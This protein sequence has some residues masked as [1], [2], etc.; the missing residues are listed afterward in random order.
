LVS[1]CRKIGKAHADA[2]WNLISRA[3]SGNIG[4][5]AMREIAVPYAVVAAVL[6]ARFNQF[7]RI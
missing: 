5:S 3:P 4:S 7:E 2:F 1:N 6:V